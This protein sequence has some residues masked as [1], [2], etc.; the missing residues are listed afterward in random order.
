M[1][2][3]TSWVFSLFTVATDIPGDHITE[4][5][6]PL[7]WER[8][9]H[10]FSLFAACHKSAITQNLHVVRKSR[11]SNIQFLKK[12]TYHGID[13][14]YFHIISDNLSAKY[15][16]DLSNER[17]RDVIEKRRNLYKLIGQEILRL[18]HTHWGYTMYAYK[19]IKT[20]TTE[21]YYTACTH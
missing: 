14:S 8:I 19:T 6:D 10:P 18:W 7:W 15:D 5:C 17:K 1:L 13:F 16:A 12:H 11:L 9:M 21:I 20:K 2:T 3:A 4:W